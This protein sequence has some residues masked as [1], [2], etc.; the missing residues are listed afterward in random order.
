M[1]LNPATRGTKYQ[2]KGPNRSANSPCASKLGRLRVAA[3]PL[4]VLPQEQPLWTRTKPEFGVQAKENGS[5]NTDPEARMQHL[6][7][8]PEFHRSTSSSRLPPNTAFS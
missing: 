4:Q 3:K 8:G 5:I 6:C 7:E 2:E 1:D